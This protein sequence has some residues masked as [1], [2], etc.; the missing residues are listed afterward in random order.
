MSRRSRA[1]KA[2]LA[3]A[4]GGGGAGL[5]GVFGYG[6]LWGEAKLAR[7]TVRP[8]TTGA[9]IADGEYGQRRAPGD[10][11]LRLAVLGDS[12]ASGV[13][14]VSADET[15]GALLA[16][17]LAAE[18]AP[19]V[20]DVLAVSGSRSSDLEPQVSRALLSPPHVAVICIGVNDV[21]HRVPAR[22]AVRNL[23]AAVTRLRAAGAGVVVGTCPDLG[24][25]KPIAQPLRTVARLR[26]RQMAAE[27]AVAV[28]HAGGVPVV[29]ADLLAAR[30][31]SEVD[32][33]CEDRFHPSPRG[34]ALLADVLL[35]A[36]RAAAA[37][38][39]PSAPDRAAGAQPGEPDALPGTGAL[40]G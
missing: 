19:V 15:P 20:L 29:L 34:Y 36:V 4:M 10:A 35:P 31:D 38:S 37:L 39:G 3:T 32:L 13:G 21:T 7:R 27:Q 30:F 17:A 28:A 33:F 1:R 16:T 2:A 9:P 12:S 24:T 6:V 5:L 25:I 26:S 11:P 8:P 40:T 22:K 14:C 18:G 23:H